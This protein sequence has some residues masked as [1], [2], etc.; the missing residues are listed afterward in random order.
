[1]NKLIDGINIWSGGEGL[2]AVLTN[3]TELAFKKGKLKNHYPI[4]YNNIS[5]KDVESVYQKFKTESDE[6][7]DD[8]MTSLICEKFRTYPQIPSTIKEYGGIDFL[9]KCTHY[10]RAKTKR[11]K[12]WEGNGEESRFIRNLVRAYLMFDLNKKLENTVV[13]N[14]IG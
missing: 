14:E 8:L 11:F 7:N 3:M 1:M 6:W 2:G 13:S 4:D 9:R 5:F 10:T 12:S